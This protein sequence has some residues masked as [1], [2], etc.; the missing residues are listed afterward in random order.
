M[1]E[2]AFFTWKLFL[3]SCRM[4][5]KV[6]VDDSYS[7]YFLISITFKIKLR[8]LLDKLLYNKNTSLYQRLLKPSTQTGT[9]YEHWST[10]KLIKFDHHW[11]WQTRQWWRWRRRRQW[12]DHTSW[13]D[14]FRRGESLGRPKHYKW[15]SKISLLPIVIT[16]WSD[17]WLATCE[18]V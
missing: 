14:D 1:M 6:D 4:E 18:A 3:R 9:L 2:G 10:N 12:I 16:C 11:H 17:R 13:D 15:S 8:T 7:K 5:Q